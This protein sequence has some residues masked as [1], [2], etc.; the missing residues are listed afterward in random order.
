MSELLQGDITEDSAQIAL[1]NYLAKLDDVAKLEPCGVYY[2]EDDTATEI[3]ND[4][5]HVVA[6]TR[7]EPQVLL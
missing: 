5:I 7:H 3:N 6:R 1:L 2:E 4:V